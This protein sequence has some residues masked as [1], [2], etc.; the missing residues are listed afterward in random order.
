MTGER[1]MQKTAAIIGSGIGGIGAGIRLAKKGYHVDIFEKNNYPGGKLSEIH[2]NSFRFDA[3]PS[4]FTLP[5]Q[6]E[7]LFETAG[8]NTAS[9]FKYHRLP[10]SGAYFFPDGVNITAHSEKEWFIEEL[11]K[12]AGEPKAN[13]DKFLKKCEELYALTAPVFIFSPFYKLSNFL[14]KESLR[15]GRNYKKLDAFKTMAEVIDG[16]FKTRHARQLFK[17][18]ATYNGSNPYTAPGTLNV[19]PHLEHNT[20]AFF[21]E[22]GMYDITRSLVNLAQKTG[23][24]FHYD[25]TVQNINIHNK[26]AK[27]FIVNDTEHT[28]NIVVSDCDV[29]TLYH[30]HLPKL[31][32][33][34]K[35]LKEERS[36]SALI[37]YW[38]INKVFPELDLHNILF[39]GNYPE[40]FRSLFERKDMYSDPTVY[41]FISK[42]QVPEDAP[43]GKENWFVMI[44]VPENTGQDWDEFI[45]QARGHIIRKINTILKTNIEQYIELESVLDPRSIEQKTGS[46]HGSLYG[47]SSNSRFSAFRRHP[48]V[49]KRIKNMYFVGGSVHPGGGI[50]LCLASAKIAVDFV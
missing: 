4:L 28:A 46:W 10:N 13:T 43:Q 12:K 9:H 33:P 5:E 42:K 35:Y 37:F 32:I 48:N 11:F 8:E 26:Q 31:Q 3:G 30:H 40:E 6:V 2:I 23:V 1:R 25:S 21:P 24:D 14:H 19:I 50:P 18:Y 38:G 44:N 27:G 39:S 17:R 41:I 29:T 49:R 45:K 36:S 20:G 15:V 47:G 34:A 22:K 7:D 16:H